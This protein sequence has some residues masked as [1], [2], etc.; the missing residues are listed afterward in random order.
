MRARLPKDRA[1]LMRNATD[2]GRPLFRAATWANIRGRAPPIVIGHS[3]S[4]PLQCNLLEIQIWFKS[5]PRERREMGRPTWRV[6]H[7][8]RRRISDD[9]PNLAGNGPRKNVP[10]LAPDLVSMSH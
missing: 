9:D 4:T 3:L 2:L 10:G 8:T 5:E 7:Q 1:R 6:R